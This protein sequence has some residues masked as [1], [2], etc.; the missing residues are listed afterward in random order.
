MKTYFLLDRSTNTWS[1]D[2]YELSAILATPGISEEQILS[3]SRTRQMF[4][5]A[6]AR[7]MLQQR[8]RLNTP[9]SGGPKLTLS[10]PAGSSVAQ[11]N[12]NKTLTQGMSLNK[13]KPKKPGDSIPLS[14]LQKKQE[15]EYKTICRTDSVFNG[16]FTPHSLSKVLNAHA[17][18]GWR[19]V[20]S[21]TAP[22]YAADGTEY[23]E[24]FVLLER[25]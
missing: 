24:F 8:P 1:T 15:R 4:T 25:G 16:R 7:T 13:D 14:S 19:V 21:N 10:T 2:H 6:Q 3:D 12:G 22:S 9:S 18:Q 11:K 20:S 17:K 23:Q 5:V